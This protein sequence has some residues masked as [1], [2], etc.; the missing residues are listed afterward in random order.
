MKGASPLHHDSPEGK[1]ASVGGQGCEKTPSKIS[2]V[3]IGAGHGQTSPYSVI[4]QATQR[5]A[6]R[7]STCICKIRDIKVLGTLRYA[8]S[9]RPQGQ[10]DA[11]I[12]QRDHR[13]TYKK[14][15]WQVISVSRNPRMQRRASHPGQCKNRCEGGTQL[16]WV[17]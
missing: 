1:S 15:I 17:G 2:K 14:G 9:S 4:E 16:T 8:V 11:S 5:V 3:G 7:Q 10:N 13:K 12:I 6:H